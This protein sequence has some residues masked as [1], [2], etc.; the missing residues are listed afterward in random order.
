MV[1]GP[2]SETAK[3]NTLRLTPDLC[4][5]SRTQLRWGES[6]SW[7]NIRMEGRKTKGE[8]RKEKER[9]KEKAGKKNGEMDK[10]KGRKEKDNRR[11]KE[12]GEEGKAL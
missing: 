7:I 12:S 5:R 3:L 9:R 6:F 10:G 4:S 8:E 2:L 11:R 1:D